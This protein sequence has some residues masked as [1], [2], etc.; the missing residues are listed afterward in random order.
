M[1]AKPVPD[2]YHTVTPYVP[3]VD[4][5]YRRALRAGAAAIMEPPD[6]F[7]G[8]RHCGVRDAAGNQWW[9][10]THIEDVSPEEMERRS[11]GAFKRD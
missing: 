8:D 10:A 2:R 7:Y 1:S 6:Q 3:D 11:G 5:V 4:A 9:I